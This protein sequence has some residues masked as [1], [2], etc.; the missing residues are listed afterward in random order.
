MKEKAKASAGCTGE[1]FTPPVGF[2]RPIPNDKHEQYRLK[3]T[4]LG[5]FSFHQYDLDICK[6]YRQ[7]DELKERYRNF[8]G[9]PFLNY[10]KQIKNGV[11]LILEERKLDTDFYAEHFYYVLHHD[12]PFFKS[13]LGLF[14]AL[15]DALEI[16]P[17]LEYH[18]ERSK[19]VNP[20][21][22]SSEIFFNE[23]EYTACNFIRT[24]RF[25]EDYFIKHD[26]IMNWVLSK[27]EFKIYEKTLETKMALLIEAIN[28]ATS[29][30]ITPKIVDKI[31]S[32]GK[33]AVRNRD[34]NIVA[35]F[36]EVLFED[37]KDY[38]G[39]KS[40]NVLKQLFNGTAPANLKVIFAGN[41]NQ[42]VDV[43]RIYAEDK[44]ISGSKRD[45][46]TWICNHFMYL[47]ENKSIPECFDPEAT[48]N[49]I[50]GQRPPTKDKRIPLTGL[51]ESRPAYYP[52][53]KPV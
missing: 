11:E 33:P 18:Y 16:V 1:L 38:Y 42:L 4:E 43:F 12:D 2:I 36:R 14:L 21:S 51:K 29:P 19:E 9:A 27:R 5:P 3:Y 24:N 13:Y 52:L 17:I 10:V 30:R 6:I 49:M 20:E 40:Q 32:K 7:V 39:K 31:I 15:S 44:K 8:N 53:K 37:L 48:E 47:A 41:A 45:I 46:A 35:G 34:I 22:E 25:P 23:L 28:K 26:K 50:Y